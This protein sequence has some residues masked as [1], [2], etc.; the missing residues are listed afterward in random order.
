MHEVLK[1]GEYTIYVYATGG[2]CVYHQCDNT[3]Q[4]HSAT[5]AE[6]VLFIESIL[7]PGKKRLFHEDDLLL[8]CTAANCAGHM[9]KAGSIVVEDDEE[10]LEC[11][12]ELLNVYETAETN[13][14]Y[15]V[16]DMFLARFGKKEEEACLQ[17][18][19]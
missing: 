7:R 14:F 3:R 12:I 4:Y 13:F 9:E 2:Y 18:E 11:I 10:L 16:E 6:S 17:S 5:L 8:A 15:L 1:M 19:T